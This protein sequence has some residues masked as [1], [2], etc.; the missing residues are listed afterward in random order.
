MQAQAAADINIQDID[1]HTNITDTDIL[2]EMAPAVNGSSTCTD[3]NGHRNHSA[4]STD[5][6]AYSNDTNGDHDGVVHSERH[7]LRTNTDNISPH[8]NASINEDNRMANPEEMS[9]FHEIL[10]DIDDDTESFVLNMP[11]PDENHT[12]NID[13]TSESYAGNT[14]NLRDILDIDQHPPKLQKTRNI[15]N[16]CGQPPRCSYCGPPPRCDNTK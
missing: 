2:D 3:Y 13:F 11:E 4:P 5:I 16:Y 8:H 14:A 1:L 9:I 12:L 10:R 15:T 7:L 6:Q